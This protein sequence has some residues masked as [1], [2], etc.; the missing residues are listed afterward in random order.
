MLL[1]LRFL[2]DVGNVNQFRFTQQIEFSADDSQNLYF[3]LVDLSVDRADES[4]NPPGR[5]YVPAATSTLSVEFL[6]VECQKVV[7]RSAVQP[8]TQDPSIWMVPILGSDPL[9]G[10]IIMK[11]KLQEPTRTL[12]FSSGKGIVLRIR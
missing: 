9:Q 12:N 10:T 8:F 5:R 2:L 3:Q 4:Y 7:I 11:V 6:S 1:S